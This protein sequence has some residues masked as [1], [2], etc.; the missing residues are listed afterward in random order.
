VVTVRA[1]LATGGSDCERVTEN[2]LAQPVN[3]VSS[4]AYVAVGAWVA[5]RASGAAGRIFGVLV[6][7][8]GVGS[9][10]YH[11]WDGDG[12]GIAHDL[13][14][15]AVAVFIL[16]FEATHARSHRRAAGYV[17]AITALAIGVAAN[18]LGRT[19]APL[20][21]PGSVVQWHALWHVATAVALGAWAWG[22][23]L[24][25]SINP[26]IRRVRAQT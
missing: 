18:L 24:V 26:G 7:L 5:L 9:I 16:G 10:A 8:T 2:L 15:V 19:G 11:G 23:L 21:V 3:T 12:V 20:C 17:V 6:A 1:L 13:S 22:A 25:W 14:I 4:L